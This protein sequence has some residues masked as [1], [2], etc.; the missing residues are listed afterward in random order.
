M[1]YLVSSSKTRAKIL[2]EAGVEFAQRPCGFDEESIEAKTPREFVYK[3]TMGKFEWAKKE[4]GTDT[5]ILCADTVVTAAGEILRKPKDVDDARDILSKQSGKSVGIVTCT[6]YASNT[7]TFIDLSITEYFF[8]EFDKAALESYLASNEWDGKAGGCMVEG[9]CK[10]YIVSQRG[11]ES[12]A[13]G[14]T[15]EKLLPFL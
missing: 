5:P 10:E 3:A 11:L 6:A 4:Y 1:L 12:C 15:I 13:M 7:L 9:F 2:C 8:K 14:L